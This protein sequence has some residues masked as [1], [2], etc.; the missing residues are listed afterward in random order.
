VD[1]FSKLNQLEYLGANY[2]IDFEKENY[3][4]NKRNYDLILDVIA[5]KSMLSYRTALTK[6]G[7]FVMIG[8]KVS[9]ILN[10]AFFGSILSLFSSRKIKILAHRP[11]ADQLEVLKEMV[12]KGQIKA[13]VDKVFSFEK[14]PQAFK[15]YEDKKML[16]KIVICMNS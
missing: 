15:Y 14:L 13:V 8:G 10:A 3:T 11:D 4:S 1:A 9:T 7:N 5:D 12:E 6:N 2:T 16:G